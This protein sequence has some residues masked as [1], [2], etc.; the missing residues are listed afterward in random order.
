[1]IVTSP[2]DTL[3]TREIGEMWTTGWL[4]SSHPPGWSEGSPSTGLPSGGGTPRTTGCAMQHDSS[5]KILM[6]T[7]WKM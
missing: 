1:M 6:D 5:P 3:T 7:A 4:G 2:E